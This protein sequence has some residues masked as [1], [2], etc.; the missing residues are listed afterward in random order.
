MLRLISWKRSQSSLEAT[1]LKAGL[2]RK[3]C[4][5]SAKEALTPK[6]PTR[7]KKNIILDGEDSIT[8]GRIKKL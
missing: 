2:D 5:S 1:A 4:G 6:N 7:L 8:R 3:G